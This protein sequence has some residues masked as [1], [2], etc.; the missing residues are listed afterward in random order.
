MKVVFLDFDGPIIPIM[1][2]KT[3]RHLMEKA[4]PPCIAAL[5]RITDM[6]GA[7]IVLSTSWRWGKNPP[8]AVEL[9]TK[10]GATGEI[11]GQTPI[12]ETVWKPDSK[13]WV[14]V[15]RGREIQAWLDEHPE[16]EKFVILDDDK[17]MEHLMSHLIH[18]PFE[19]GLTEADAD[20]AIAILGTIEATA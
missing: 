1:S 6:T 2:H 20:K 5:N 10:W 14:E 3:F 4:W 19:V 18:T 9:I 11:I 15:P 17:D 7:K 13:L 12:L 16:V 8:T